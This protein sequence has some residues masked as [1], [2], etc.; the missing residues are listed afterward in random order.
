MIEAC[1]RAMASRRFFRLKSA[2]MVSKRKLERY[3][4]DLDA[5]VTDGQRHVEIVFECPKERKPDE[6]YPFYSLARGIPQ[7]MARFPGR[8]RLP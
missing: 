6:K 1:R 4:R 8:R 2:E 3:R 7:L 5:L